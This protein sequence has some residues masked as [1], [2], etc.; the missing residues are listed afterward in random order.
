MAQH[1]FVPYVVLLTGV[2]IAATSSIL[3]RLAQDGGN[4]APS[5]VIAGWRLLVASVV[6]T[7]LV[8]RNHRPELRRLPRPDLRW[9]VIAGV[10]LAA[11]L[12]TWIASLAY[13]SVASSAALVTTN[14]LWVALAVRF[15]YGERLARNTV[16]GLAAGFIGSLLIALSDC[17]ILMAEI[18]GIQLNLQNLLSPP[19]KADTALFGDFLALLGAI[20]VAG[21]LLVGRDLRRRLSNTAYVWLV[22]SVAAVTMVVV[23]LVSGYSFTGYRPEIYLWMTLLGLGPQ[24]LGHTAFNWALAH[25]SA[26]FVALT[27]LGEPIGSA[28]LAYFL[29]DETFAPV[30]LLGFLL[31]MV[32]ITLGVMGEQKQ[33]AK[34]S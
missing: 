26:T 23:I 14:P 27:I 15:I 28:I 34:R 2:F 3:A 29:F 11:H 19:D 7:P 10:L 13:T 5:M 24:L 33:P 32:G 20:T 25:L 6:L 30:Q 9:G 21:Y 4:G 16:L 1:R 8:W 31:L 22:Y 17:G 12:G 18:S